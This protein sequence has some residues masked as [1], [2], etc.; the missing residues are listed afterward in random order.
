[1]T[2]RIGATGATIAAQASEGG[3]PTQDKGGADCVP[4]MSEKQLRQAIYDL[5]RHLGYLV[6]WTWTSRHSPPGFPDLVL[7]RDGRIVFAELK[8]GRNRT[9]AAQDAWLAALR[10]C[11]LTAVVWRPEDW[12]S[13]EIEGKL[14]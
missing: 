10:R 1:V 7:V 9:T 5:A 13:G 2:S 14:R 11:G 6:Y 3:G 12:H 8:V 4:R